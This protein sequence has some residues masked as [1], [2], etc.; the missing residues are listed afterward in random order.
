MDLA[1]R[2]KELSRL[3]LDVKLELIARNRDPQ[4]SDSAYADELGVSAPSLS[5]WIKGSRMPDFQNTHQLSKH[6]LIGNKIYDIVGFD[7]PEA[8]TKNPKLYYIQQNLQYLDD[9]VQDEIFNRIKKYL[10]GLEHGDHGDNG[11]GDKPG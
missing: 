1:T 10:E 5:H 2:K 6:R 7:P 9:D 3:L 4:M 8:S 11:G